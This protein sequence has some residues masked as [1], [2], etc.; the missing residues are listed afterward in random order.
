MGRS[1][2]IQSKTSDKAIMAVPVKRLLYK[3]DC[4]FPVSLIRTLFMKKEQEAITKETFNIKKSKLWF[5]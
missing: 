1:Y 5:V 4:K 2:G 3:A